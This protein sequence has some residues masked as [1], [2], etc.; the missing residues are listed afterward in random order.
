MTGALSYER[1]TSVLDAEA[2]TVVIK[3]K[4]GIHIVERTS[5]NKHWE[6]TKCI[7]HGIKM[8]KTIWETI[9]GKENIQEVK[10]MLLPS[11]IVKLF[12]KVF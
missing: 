8:T 11:S 9:G 5:Q 10:I 6:K 1:K 7:S 2:L 12:D 4:E 3:V